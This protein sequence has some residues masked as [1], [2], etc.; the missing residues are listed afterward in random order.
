M[1][2]KPLLLGYPKPLDVNYA[3]EKMSFGNIS[4]ELIILSQDLFNISS[5]NTLTVF[6]DMNENIFCFLINRILVQVAINNIFHTRRRYQKISAY[7]TCRLT[8]LPVDLDECIF[9]DCQ[10]GDLSEE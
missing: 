4:T 7:Q 1:L 5:A 8:E 9:F 3:L 10:T 6:I 2:N